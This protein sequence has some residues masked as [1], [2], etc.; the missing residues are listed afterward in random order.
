[1]KRSMLAPGVVAVLVLLSGCASDYAYN[2]VYGYPD[3]AYG[4]YG[5]PYYGG[6]DEFGYPWYGG[7]NLGL[8][9]HDYGGFGYRGGFARGRFADRFRSGNFERGGTR[10]GRFAGAGRNG[11]SAR[12]AITHGGAGVAHGGG[13]F[14]RGGGGG[15]TRGGGGGSARGH[16]THR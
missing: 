4:A 8:G 12:G 14:A 15:F 7:L 13:A 11:G 1:M 9:F 16:G 3:Q 6:Y 2:D 10:T 5:Y